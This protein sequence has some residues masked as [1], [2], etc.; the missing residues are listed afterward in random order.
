MSLQ[1]TCCC[2]FLARYPLSQGFHPTEL[3]PSAW[4]CNQ[5]CRFNSHVLATFLQDITCLKAFSPDWIN[6]RLTLVEPK[7]CQHDPPFHATPLL[8][9]LVSR[10]SLDQIR[11]SQSWQK[12]SNPKD[13]EGKPQIGFLIWIPQRSQPNILGTTNLIGRYQS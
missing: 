4:S 11:I 12:P 10:L 3:S 9:H 8:T 5:Q 2:Y 6:L 7:I 1:F 13:L